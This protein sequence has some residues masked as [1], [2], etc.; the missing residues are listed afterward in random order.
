MFISGARWRQFNKSRMNPGIRLHSMPIPIRRSINACLCTIMLP[1]LGVEKNGGPVRKWLTLHDFSC[2]FRDRATTPHHWPSNLRCKNWKLH[3]RNPPGRLFP[4]VAWRTLR[5]SFPGILP[6]YSWRQIVYI[7]LWLN[8][9]PLT[10]LLGLQYSC[11][12]MGSN[13]NFLNWI[14]FN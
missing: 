7:F 3:S 5:I 6:K 1:P 2:T 14:H 10:D 11:N 4:G 8:N 12:L 9:C 13:H